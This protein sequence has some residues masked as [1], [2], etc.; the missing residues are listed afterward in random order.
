MCVGV[1]M[2]V[3]V[4]ECVCM[5]SIRCGYDLLSWLP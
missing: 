2:S 1:L 4:C 3:C 5:Y